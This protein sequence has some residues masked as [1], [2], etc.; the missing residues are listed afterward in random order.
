MT[1]PAPRGSSS[2]NT[3]VTLLVVVALVVGLMW[4]GRSRTPPTIAELLIAAEVP[5]APVN[6]DY[7]PGVGVRNGGV[8]LGE[9]L[10]R[11][12]ATEAYTFRTRR[13]DRGGAVRA[14]EGVPIRVRLRILAETDDWSGV[15]PK[16]G[17]I[18]STSVPRDRGGVLT[19]TGRTWAGGL[20]DSEGRLQVEVKLEVPVGDDPRPYRVEL[21]ADEFELSSDERTLELVAS[22]VLGVDVSLP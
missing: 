18:D 8:W 7:D 22:T 6:Y 13:M 14:R 3:V 16:A 17:F 15:A 20:T 19:D 12:G 1:K 4:Y 11:A 21:V 9:D 10:H 2:T 5:A